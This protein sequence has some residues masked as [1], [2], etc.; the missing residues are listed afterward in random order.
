[1]EPGSP[2][3]AEVTGAPEWHRK[4][5]KEPTESW[6]FTPKKS[7]KKIMGPKTGSFFLAT[8]RKMEQCEIPLGEIEKV[9][10]KKS[11]LLRE[12]RREEYWS[13]FVAH[14]CSDGYFII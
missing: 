5:G 14:K 8:I 7:G 11:H 13:F 6:S 2:T 10:K 9:K 3:G 1:M 12:L 4:G